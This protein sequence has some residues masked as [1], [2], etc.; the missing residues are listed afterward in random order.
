MKGAS[1]LGTLKSSAEATGKFAETAQSLYRKEECT[2]VGRT[3]ASTAKNPTKLCCFMFFTG[4][5]QHNSGM[6]SLCYSQFKSRIFSEVPEFY[7]ISNDGENALILN[8][9][10]ID[11]AILNLKIR[12]PLK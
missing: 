3:F 5:F 6:R 12:L 9:L 4:N 1:N 10:F 11:K 2:I 8:V 7:S